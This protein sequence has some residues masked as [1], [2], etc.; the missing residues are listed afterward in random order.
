MSDKLELHD[1]EIASEVIAHLTHTVEKVRKAQGEEIVQFLFLTD[2]HH[3]TA[4]NQLRTAALVNRLIR[5]CALDCIVCGGDISENGDK[6]YVLQAQKEMMDALRA[7]E[8]P[9]LPVKGNHDDNSIYDYT[10]KTGGTGHVIFPEEMY[11]TLFRQLEG[12]AVFDTGNESGL[13]YYYDIPGKRTR[14]IILNCI[15]I[16]YAVTEQG[17]LAQNGQWEYAFSN[18]QL[19][20]ME[21]EALNFSTHTDGDGWKAVVFSHVSILQD[22]VYGADHEV[23]G[24]EA[25]WSIIRANRS[26]VAACFFGHVHYDQVIVR[27]GIP[28]ISSLNAVTYQD[29]ESAP[30]R[31]L[32]TITETAFDIV[33]IDY[34]KGKLQAIRFGAGEDRTIM[35]GGARG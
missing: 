8:Y 15:D 23:A 16:P 32:H 6:A 21:R 20:W 10:N 30:A 11:R 12:T 28:T 14:M 22:G 17:G 9:L 3:R 25:M 26:R 35:L 27:D 7:P 1:I 19:H 31:A 24:G 34:S 5:D 2:P 13:Y 18:R 29:F 4:G 33:S